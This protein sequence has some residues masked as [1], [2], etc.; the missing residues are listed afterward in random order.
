[1]LNFKEFLLGF[2]ICGFSQQIKRVKFIWISF[3]NVI[4]L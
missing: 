1:M 3:N 2:H 4:K